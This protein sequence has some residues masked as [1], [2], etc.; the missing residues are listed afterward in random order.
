MSRLL[1]NAGGLINVYS[2][3]NGYDRENHWTKPENLRYY[4]GNSFKA[5][6]GYHYT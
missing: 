1:N 2:E 6:Q 3:I 4:I 5:G